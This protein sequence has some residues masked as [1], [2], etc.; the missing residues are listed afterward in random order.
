M[1]IM[2]GC[3][4]LVTTLCV[5][6]GEE[7][8]L[9]DVT[10]EEFREHYDLDDVTAAFREKWLG[11]SLSNTAVRTYLAQ[12]VHFLG[13]VRGRI[14]FW[15]LK[16]FFFF[17]ILTRCV[18]HITEAFF[19]FTTLLKLCSSLVILTRP[20]YHIIFLYDLKRKPVS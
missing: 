5:C 1:V 14:Q 18:Y 11:C 15:D 16:H 19:L 10:M 8:D 3:S 9:L 4:M 7:T 17:V 12:T 2:R 13:L 20:V 6:S